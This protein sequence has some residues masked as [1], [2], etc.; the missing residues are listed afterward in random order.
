[1]E[2]KNSRKKRKGGKAEDKTRKISRGGESNQDLKRYK[3]N[4]KYQ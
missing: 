2:K 1:M 4:L 3:P